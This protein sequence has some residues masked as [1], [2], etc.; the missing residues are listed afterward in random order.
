MKTRQLNAG[1]KGDMWTKKERL[2]AAEKEEKSKEE[3]EKKMMKEDKVP[4]QQL[5]QLAFSQN[6]RDR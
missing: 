3:I 2:K 6:P 5:T 4:L 1:K